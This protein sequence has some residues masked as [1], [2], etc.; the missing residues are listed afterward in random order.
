VCS[1]ALTGLWK[2]SAAF[3]MQHKSAHDHHWMFTILMRTAATLRNIRLMV[4]NIITLHTGIAH[5]IEHNAHGKPP[6]HGFSLLTSVECASV[7]HY[8]M[9]IVIGKMCG[10]HYLRQSKI[11]D[12]FAAKSSKLMNLRLFITASAKVCCWV[13]NVFSGFYRYTSTSMTSS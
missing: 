1:C 11:P 8:P 9:C 3:L 6:H 10:G 4:E 12:F 13:V 2:N 5:H 7:V